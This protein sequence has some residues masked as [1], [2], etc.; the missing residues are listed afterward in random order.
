MRA[1]IRG[2]IALSVAALAIAAL[3]ALFAPN[4]VVVDVAEVKRGRM[5][6]TVSS[7]GRTRVKHEYEVVAP[8]GGR[9]LR[10]N[11]KAGDKVVAGETVVAV[12]E[13]PQ[14]QFHDFRSIGELEAKVRATEALN[15][16]AAAD[17]ERAKAEYQFA[18]RELERN[19]ELI[20]AKVV[21]QKSLEE[22]ERDAKTREVAIAVAENL[23]RQRAFELEAAKA[24][25][26]EPRHDT[27]SNRRT[28]AP[29]QVFAP[30]NGRV[31]VVL[32]ESETIVTPGTTI[33]KIGDVRNLEVMLEMLSES[34]VKVREGATAVLDG[35]G[36][37]QLNARVRRVEPFG[38]TKVSA[39][40][41]EE[42]RVRVYLDFVDRPTEGQ[43]LG[44]GYRVTAHIVVWQADNVPKMPVGALFRDG[45]RWA[46]FVATDQTARLRHVEV[47]NVNNAEAEI[48][49]GLPE[50][51]QV[52]L[53][54][55]DRITDGV[56][57]RVRRLQ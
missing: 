55:S 4:P 21:S 7:E 41:I 35:W 25:L 26:I 13:P 33:M 18:K 32:K 52:I 29:V 11:Q 9:L 49:N 22:S 23:L 2:L 42:Q 48:L 19:R 37:K 20:G 45:N 24:S 38:F 10:V 31:L 17:L 56:T 34:A 51:A 47:G 53:N 36:G 54:P 14:P 16:L 40:G 44:D 8:L 30:A 5:T 46:A 28:Q 57:I 27:E 3:A 6:V 12:I 50:G 39:L 1:L 43:A 15:A